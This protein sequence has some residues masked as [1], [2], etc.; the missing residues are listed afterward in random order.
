MKIRHNSHF[1]PLATS[2]YDMCHCDAPCNKLCARRKIPPERY[3]SAAN[4][5]FSCSDFTP[6]NGIHVN[7]K[8]KC[9]TNSFV[10]GDKKFND[11]L[12]PGDVLCFYENG[13]WHN[14]LIDAKNKKCV[15]KDILD[16]KF[17][18]RYVYHVEPNKIEVE[19][20]YVVFEDWWFVLE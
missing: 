13:T 9:V 19:L 18:I 10:W 20:K 6:K 7:E 12:C 4:F 5:M 11:L 3:F 8:L 1:L 2:M 15:I 14:F 17:N 16:R